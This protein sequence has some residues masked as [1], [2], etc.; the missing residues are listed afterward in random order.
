[1]NHLDDV[2]TGALAGEC[3]YDSDRVPTIDQVQARADSHRS[4]LGRR[5]RRVGT[6]AAACIALAGI[7]VFANLREG[8]SHELRGSSP[9]TSDPAHAADRSTTSLSGTAADGPERFERVTTGGL[10]VTLLAAPSTALTQRVTARLKQ[11]TKD[12]ETAGRAGVPKRCFPD[13]GFALDI[14]R[15]GTAELDATERD[16]YALP[17][18]GAVLRVAGATGGRTLDGRLLNVV[19]V[20][21]DPTANVRV[22]LVVND[23]TVDTVSPQAGWAVL[24][25]VTDDLSFLS[26]VGIR[27][28][29]VVT[30][31]SGTQLGRLDVPAKETPGE[32]CPK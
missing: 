25:S 6:V 21:T 10:S 16:G 30:N 14:T 31:P 7:F 13:R 18:D 11:A 26:N 29:V 23:R 17:L 15:D 24:V 3:S 12:A 4:R 27:G 32:Y 19:V 9:A 5:R 20:R 1:M 8:A 22:S 2:V 28:A